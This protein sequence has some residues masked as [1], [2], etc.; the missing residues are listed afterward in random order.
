MPTINELKAAGYHGL[1]AHC[2]RCRWTA[3]FFW[4]L[5]PADG[6]AEIKLLKGRFR[7]TRCGSVPAPEDVR[8][9]YLDR[10]TAFPHVEPPSK[11]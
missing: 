8:P 6:S 5:I 10:S 2:A 4:S 9:Y 11:R 3:Q 1:E 7:C